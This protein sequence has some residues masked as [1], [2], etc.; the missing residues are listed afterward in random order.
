LTGE[1]MPFKWTISIS[2][3]SYV[4]CCLLAT[5]DISC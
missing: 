3:L 4:W 1:V 2:V 5:T